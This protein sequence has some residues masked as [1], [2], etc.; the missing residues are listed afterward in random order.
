M[1]QPPHKY[2]P[3]ASVALTKCDQED[4]PIAA[5]MHICASQAAQGSL[6]S[7]QGCEFDIVIFDPVA[8]GMDIRAKAFG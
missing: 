1:W 3:I 2:T 8:I 5:L 4:L 7:T 6:M